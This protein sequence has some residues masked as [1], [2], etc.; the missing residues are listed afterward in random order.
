MRALAWPL[1]CVLCAGAGAVGGY[2]ALDPVS[3]VDRAQQAILREYLA[4]Y[5]SSPDPGRAQFFAGGAAVMSRV[6]IR[7]GLGE[8]ALAESTRCLVLGKNP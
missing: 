6:A 8:L 7:A 3:R 5:C 1:I 4:V 2:L